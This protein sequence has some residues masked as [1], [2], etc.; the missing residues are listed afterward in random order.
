MGYISLFNL[1]TQ[2]G[3]ANPTKKEES[4]AMIIR[5]THIVL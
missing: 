4:S 1:K 2:P 3:F 5:G